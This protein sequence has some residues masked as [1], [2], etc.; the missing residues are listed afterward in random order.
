MQRKQSGDLPKYVSFRT[1][2]YD[3][4]FPAVLMWSQKSSCTLVLTWFLH[5]T[6]R[7][8]EARKYHRWLHFYENQVLK[9]NGYRTRLSRTIRQG[10]V[11]IVKFVRNP[12]AR[13]VSSFI[14]L[15]NNNAPFTHEAWRS[16][17]AYHYDDADSRSGISFRQFVDWL[18]F[19]G[20]SSEN[21]NGHFAQQFVEGEDALPRMITNVENVI[22]ELRKMEDLFELPP[23]P[24]SVFAET[25]HSTKYNYSRDLAA[26]TVIHPLST[27][28]IPR[29]RAFYDDSIRRKIHEMFRRDFEEYGY[30]SSLVF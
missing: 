18:L 10:E 30:T 27:L 22:D 4:G 7:L 15:R 9:K 13:A 11:P 2:L 3:A 8:D 23:A 29:W 17:R 6:G 12:Y 20:V 19:T 21:I 26:D 25:R 28:E 24:L 5:H 14:T 1:P 16:L